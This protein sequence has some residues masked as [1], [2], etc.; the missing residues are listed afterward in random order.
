[1]VQLLS[2]KERMNLKSS[3]HFF[4]F[5]FIQEISQIELW[6]P[7]EKITKIIICMFDFTHFLNEIQIKKNEIHIF[8]IVC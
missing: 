1:M 3:C 2:K 7:Y 4:I 8:S 5:A 6:S